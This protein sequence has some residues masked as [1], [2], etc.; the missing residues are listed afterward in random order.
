MMRFLSWRLKPKA[1][2]TPRIGRGPGTDAVDCAAVDEEA[3]VAVAYVHACVAENALLNGT[4]PG[5]T[6]TYAYKELTGEFRGPYAKKGPHPKFPARPEEL[7]T[8]EAN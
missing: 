3:S 2:A 7:P 4:S 1:A 5:L 6:G 8:T